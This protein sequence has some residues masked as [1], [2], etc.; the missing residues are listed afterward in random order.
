MTELIGLK[1]STPPSTAPSATGG[2]ILDVTEA[3]FM[4]EVIDASAQTPII[5]D[6]WAPWCGPCKTLTPA[7]EAAVTAKKGK[8]R[9]AKVNVDENQA[10]AAQL[11]IQSLPTVYAFVNG[12][13]VDGFMGAVSPAEL[14]QFIDR[15]TAQAGE[16]PG[17][18]EA[19][20]AAHEMLEEGAFSDAAQTFA[21][22]LEE[23]PGHTEALAGMVRTY[24]AAGQPEQAQALL[25]GLSEADR[26]KPELTALIA[27][28]DLAASAA[29]TGETAA[30]RAELAG[31][32][33]NHQA[34]HDLALALAASGDDEGAMAELLELFRR[35][36]D[37]NDGA[38]KTQLIRIFDKLGPKDPRA[39]K[40]RR[41]LSSMIFL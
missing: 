31:D 5:V 26:A 40:G 8:I 9:L 37:W 7:L 34:R 15:V 41:Q 3:N 19:I 29:E 21:A 18:D 13:P 39:Q 12:Q 16:A 17:L 11:R 10:L 23:E 27:E 30:L 28:M 20:A 1:S 36:R 24:L 14:T 6:F 2:M 35:D 38:A 25:D 33:D 32:A 4:A 22:I